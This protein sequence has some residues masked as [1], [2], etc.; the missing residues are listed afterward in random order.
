MAIPVFYWTFPFPDLTETG[1]NN[2]LNLRKT[3]YPNIFVFQNN[4]YI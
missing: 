3:D 4:P 1:Q 2:L